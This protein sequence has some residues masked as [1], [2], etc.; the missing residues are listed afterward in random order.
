M[1]R[2]GFQQFFQALPSPHMLLDRDLNF[3]A[4]NRAYELATEQTS[5]SLVGR[6]LFE[7]FPNDGDA[8]RRLRESLDRVL[9]SGEPDTLAYIEYDIPVP[10][11]KGG[12]MTKRYWTAIHAPLTD[13]SGQVAYILQNTVDITELVQ[14][15]EAASAP[16]SL[17]SGGVALVQRAREAEKVIRDGVGPTQQFRSLFEDAPGMV[18]LLYGPDHVIT[19]ANAALKRFFGQRELLGL[20]VRKAFP[21]LE[22]EEPSGLLGRLDKTYQTG[23]SAVGF[24]TS[25]RL[26]D[27]GSDRLREYFV[28]LSHHPVASPTGQVSGIFI[29]GYDRTEAVRGQRH[30]KFLLDELNHRVKNTLSTVQSLARRS[31]RATIDRED[32]RRVFEGR[33]LALSNAHN[34]LSQHHWEAADLAAI[35][36]L[37]FAALP[38]ERITTKGGRFDLSP[39][40]AIA[41]AMVFHELASNALKYGSL[42]KNDGR[43]CVRW[44]TR[45]ETLELIWRETGPDLPET[46]DEL[47]PGFGMRMLERIVTGELEGRLELGLGPSSLTWT[48]AIPLSELEAAKALLDD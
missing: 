7:A 27:P 41:L 17:F 36:R 1:D 48:L 40:A 8:G 32:A 37:E 16:S 14:L 46:Q 30:Q 33:I 20:P 23:E 9:A 43:V 10:A 19:Y 35:A 39:K 5:S 34:L 4:V 18:A 38:P 12:G 3:V 6:Y 31:F 22:C 25:I 13:D 11:S 24:A 15:R 47:K 28:D 29:Q 21:E 2:I 42:A 45:G 26:R 44:E